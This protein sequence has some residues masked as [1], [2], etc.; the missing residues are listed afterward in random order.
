MNMIK[1]SQGT[2]SKKFAISLQYFKKEV[3]DEVRFLHER[4]TKFLQIGIIVLMEVAKHIE[5][6]QNRKSV[7][8]MQ[9]LEKMLQLF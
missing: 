6:T 4:N 5:S 9:Y 2:Q 7:I 1:H 3:K 8:F